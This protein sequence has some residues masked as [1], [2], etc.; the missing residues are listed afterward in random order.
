MGGPSVEATVGLGEPIM[1][2]HRWYDSS[3]ATDSVR[4][5]GHIVER[6]GVRADP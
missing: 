4:F 6:E 3:F 5:L 2:D 1:G